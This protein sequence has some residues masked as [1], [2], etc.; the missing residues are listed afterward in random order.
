MLTDQDVDGRADLYSLGVI[1]YQALVGDPPFDGPTPMAIL[2]KQAHEAPEP[3]RKRA[4]DVPKNLAAAVEKAL[5]KDPEDRFADAAEFAAAVRVDAAVISSGS[6]TGLRVAVTL[7]LVLAAAAIYWATRPAPP[8]VMADAAVAAQPDAKGVAQVPD[9]APKKPVDATKAAKAADAGVQVKPDAAKPKVRYVTI[10][11]TSDPAGAKVYSGRRVLG[12]TPLRV[13]R[14]ASA[15]SMR[16]T[17]KRSGYQ[18]KSVSV[19]LRKNG[20]TRVKLEPDFELVP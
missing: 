8:V 12:T 4:P 9:R 10:Q 17:L 13:R 11:V 16:L 3:L 20:A 19:P 7:V 15:R 1:T 18:D 2:Y 6:P 14:P 5:E